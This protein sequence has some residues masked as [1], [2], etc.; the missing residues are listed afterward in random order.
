MNDNPSR[1]IFN[2]QAII[3]QKTISVARKRRSKSGL[4]LTRLAN[5]CQRRRPDFNAGSMQHKFALPTQCEWQ[6]LIEIKDVQRFSANV[7]I[8]RSDD[9]QTVR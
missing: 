6:N 5:K 3:S 4:A 8:V 9:P 1:R 2:L 7:Q